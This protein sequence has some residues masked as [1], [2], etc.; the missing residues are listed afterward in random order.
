MNPIE[1]YLKTLHFLHHSGEGTA[2]TSYYPAL[3]RLL[4]EVGKSLKPRVRCIIH[5]KNKGAGIP[6]GGLFT[7][8]QFP[9][10]ADT[11][12]NLSM[13]PARGAVEVKGSHED[14]FKIVQTKQIADYLQKYRQVLVTN[15]RDFVLVGVDE[16]GKTIQLESF[17]LAENETIFWQQT[18]QQLAQ[19]QRERF[20]S[21]LQRVMLQAAPLVSPQD[22]AGLLASYAR[23]A[24]ARIDLAELTALQPIQ[25]AFEEALG[26]TFDNKQGGDV[27]FRSTLVQTLFYGIFSAWVLWHNENP[28]RT[29]RF[30]WR[31]AAYSLHVPMVQ[32]LYEEVARPT[33]IGRQGLNLEEVLDW[34]GAAL[35]RVQRGE[36][37]SRFESGHAIQYFYEPFL[38]AFSPDL[39]KRYG[40]WYTPLEIVTYMVE[41]VDRVLR[42]ELGLADGLADEQVY[43]LDPCCG[44]GAYLVACVKRIQK[45]LQEQGE[46]ALLAY[47]LKKAV[48]ERLFGFE[49]LP[50]PFVIAHLQLGLLL[51]AVGVP[52]AEG[53]RA[54]VFLTNALTGWEPPKEKPK[55]PL[56][57]ALA[58]E[59]DAA[60]QVKQKAKILVVLGNPP[61]D[62]YAGVSPAEEN[63]LVDVYKKGLREIWGI[64]KYNLDELYVRFFRLAERRIAEMTGQGVI[65]FI[66]NFSYLGDPSFVVMRQRFLQEFDSLWIDSLNG[67]SRGT[68]KR[69]PDGKPDPS[70]FSTQYNKAGIRVGTAVSLLVRR[71]QRASQPTVQYREF[72]GSNKR[73]ELLNSL[74]TADFASYYQ[75]ASSQPTNRL[76]FQPA[77]LTSNYLNWPS[78]VELCQEA[79]SNGLM[80]KRGGALIDIDREPLETRMKLYYLTDTP[81]N[82]D[83]TAKTKLEQKTWEQLE[84]MKA[85]LAQDA[86]GYI[87]RQVRLKVLKAEKF[88]ESHLQ[89][90]AV[91]P[92]D[93]RWCYYSQVSSLW[94]R[95]RPTLWAQ[96]WKGN[97]FLMSR[98]AGVANPEGIPFFYTS[99]LGDNDFQRGHAYY[100][101][102]RLRSIAL[103]EQPSHQSRLFNEH[104]Q[105]YQANLSAK[106]RVY[107]AELGVEE[108]DEREE[109]AEL[110]WLHALAIGYSPHYL[111]ENADGIRNDWPRIPLPHNRDLL[112]ASAKWGQQVAAL[113]DTEKKVAGVT[114]AILRPE[115][116]RLGSVQRA[117][118][119]ALN[120]GSDLAMTAGWGYLQ[121]E[122]ITMPGQGKAIEREYTTA[123]LTAIEQ[124]AATLNLTLEEALAQLGQTTFDIYLNEVAFW[125]NVPAKVWAYT[126]GGY[127]V[128]KKWL[129]Y[130]EERVLGRPL[131]P[132]EAYEVRDMARRLA[133]LVLLQPALNANYQAVKEQVYLW[134]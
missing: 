128:M 125:R 55:Q 54:A 66:S 3:N 29:D 120:P 80:E 115:L 15:L 45:T 44:T 14:V 132:E 47:H 20:V 124:G 61:Y 11:E 103:K 53:E 26:L 58:D 21:Y 81:E 113:L 16:Q 95:S 27:F 19:Q 130:R 87:P 42:Q 73:S 116:K 25:Q 31:L 75:L 5:L 119:G 57:P 9:K 13:L 28:S 129:S 89:K 41:R 43:V 134:K 34:A 30:E 71:P 62:A 91:R 110:L 4:E 24:K 72:W 85:A 82:L 117:D 109:T 100:F 23:E 17:R 68:G 38:Q 76:S 64:K 83:D 123:E 127:Q 126:I 52:L 107:L 96:L 69:T 84:T 74:E 77:H 90:Y 112:Q 22:V 37:F 122:S 50:A 33:R 86:A 32:S 51:Q 6:D 7:A 36:F 133:A 118:G 70:V 102:V 10:K 98:P 46:D 97:T 60:E 104:H 35:N 131:K 2:E 18:P 49:I 88:T 108:V 63:G 121:G 65:C 114:E 101:P 59:R 111:A 67:D 12:I 92:F 8:D 93:I 105:L 40:V 79:P 106:A 48:T 1:Q 78:L 56:L 94:N 99:L 39:R